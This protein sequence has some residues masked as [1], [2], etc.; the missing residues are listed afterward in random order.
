[1]LLTLDTPDLDRSALNDVAK[2]NIPYIHVGYPGYVPLREATVAFI[3]SG[4]VF[5]L[6]TRNTIV[7]G[8][9]EKQTHN[10]HSLDVP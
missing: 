10:G 7:L 9:D 6:I 1:M 5:S 4:M 8:I 2:K 3:H